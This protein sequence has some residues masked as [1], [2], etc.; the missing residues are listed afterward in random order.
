P[1]VLPADIAAYRWAGIDLG[2]HHAGS[3]RRAAPRAASGDHCGGAEC[4]RADRVEHLPVLWI[5]RPAGANA[6]ANRDDGGD[7]IVGVSAG[8]HRR[9]D[10]MERHQGVAG[11]TGAACGGS[12]GLEPVSKINGPLQ[13]QSPQFSWPLSARLG[14]CL[15]GYH[16]ILM[17]SATNEPAL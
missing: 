1:G 9:A 2:G 16:Y 4:V 12:S 15:P 6:G 14:P 8:V 5:F 7:E 13:C 10:R 11:I 17:F 3:E